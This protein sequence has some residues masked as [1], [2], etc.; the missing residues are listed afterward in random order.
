[1]ALH[2]ELEFDARRERLLTKMAEEKL[3][4][5]LLLRRRACIG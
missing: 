4:A 3:D 2:F 5:L 1:M